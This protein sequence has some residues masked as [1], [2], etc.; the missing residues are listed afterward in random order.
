M[1]ALF[2]IE[3]AGRQRNKACISCERESVSERP[4]FWRN[5]KSDLLDARSKKLE[6]DTHTRRQRTQEGDR[7]THTRTAHTRAATEVQQH[8][9]GSVARSSMALWSCATLSHHLPDRACFLVLLPSHHPNLE[10]IL[11]YYLRLLASSSSIVS[12]TTNLCFINL[13]FQRR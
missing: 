7:A 4:F 13:A 8:G 12:R 10:L 6:R 2:C 11:S 3:C 5:W 1:F 9:F